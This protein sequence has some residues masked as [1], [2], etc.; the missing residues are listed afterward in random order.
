MIIVT[1]RRYERVEG[2]SLHIQFLKTVFGMF[3]MKRLPGFFYRFHSLSTQKTA[4]RQADN[5]LTCRKQT[6]G[7]LKQHIKIRY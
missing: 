5:L 3:L 7:F 4:V 2:L 1:N 6:Y